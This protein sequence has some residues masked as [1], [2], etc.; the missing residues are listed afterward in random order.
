MID[1]RDGFVEKVVG[2]RWCVLR[3]RMLYVGG[4]GCYRLF[5]GLYKLFM[6]DFW[7]D[8]VGVIRGLVGFYLRF[9]MILWGFIMER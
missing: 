8:V 9:I 2:W 4:M 1:M 3:I 7:G 5:I 6:L